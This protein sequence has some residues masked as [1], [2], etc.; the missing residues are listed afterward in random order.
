MP[1]ESIDQIFV[2]QYK[3]TMIVLSQQKTSRLEGTTIPP[4]DVQGEYFYWE[5]IGASEAVDL[6]SRHA[7]TPNIEPDHS[8]R[9]ASAAPKVWA[10][11]LDRADQVRMLVNP[12]NYYNQIAQMAMKRAKDRLIIAA[13]ENS[14]WAGKNG[15][16]EVPL[17]AA[18]KIDAGAVG[19]TIDKILTAKEMLDISEVDPDLPRYFVVTAKQ[20]TDLLGTTEATS[21]DYNTVRA[22]AKGEIDTFCG[23]QF[24]RTQLLTLSSTTRYCYAYAKGAVGF[25]ILADMFSDIT[26]LP[27]H[28]YSWQV[29]LSQD[30]GATRVEDEQVVQVGC[31]ES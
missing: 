1:G 31:T 11:K 23:F 17:P 27:T 25:G 20:V 28:N 21:A 14:A 5:R 2:Q 29:Y 18:Q 7:E 13:L 16:E 24:I 26:Q 22:L 15:T 4:I 19:L 3:N 10:T 8:R 6:T 30:Y 9:R 12:L